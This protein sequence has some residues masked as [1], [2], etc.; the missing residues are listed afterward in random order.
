[1]R[2][3]EVVV[4]HTSAPQQRF[5]LVSDDDSVLRTGDRVGPYTVL[6][7]LG[8]GGMGIVYLARD[9]RL[10]RRV[11]LKLIRSDE[12]DEL[13]LRRFLFEVRAT[14]R[15]NH[16]NIVTVHDAG[17]HEGM[18]Y[19]VLEY[20]EGETLEQRML[21]RPLWLSEALDVALG[22][23]EALS[24]AH[25]HGILHSD[26]KPGNVM[27][28]PHDVVKVLDF[29]LA[30][31]TQV[32]DRELVD[33]ILSGDAAAAATIGGTPSFMAP[34]QWRAEPCRSASDV[35][36]L[37]MLLHEMCALRRPYRAE[38][39][40]NRVAEICRPR[41]FVSVARYAQLP[42]ELAELIDRCLCKRP[43]GRPTAREA[44]RVLRA[45]RDRHMAP[46]NLFRGGAPLG[47]G[48]GVRLVGRDFERMAARAALDDEGALVLVGP[49][50]CGKTSFL[51]AGLLAELARDDRHLVVELRPGRRPFDA[52]E[53]ALRT[54]QAARGVDSRG[55]DSRGVDS[56]E[57][58]R[59]RRPSMPVEAA[60]AHDATK[61]CQRLVRLATR[62]GRTVVLVI[63]PLDDLTLVEPDCAARFLE[64]LAHIAAL[65]RD[66]VRLVMSV[67]NY[68]LNLLAQ[69]PSLQRAAERAYVLRPLSP[70]AL[71]RALEE[72]VRMAGYHWE[73]GAVDEILEAVG[74]GHHA[75]AQ[76]Q[77]IAERIWELR[78]RA[79]LVLRRDAWQR[80]GGVAGVLCQHAARRREALASRAQRAI[81]RVLVTLSDRKRRRRMP[82]DGGA[83]RDACAML[84]DARLISWSDADG[85]GRWV[86]AHD[87][88]ASHALD[89]RARRWRTVVPCLVGAALVPLA[90]GLSALLG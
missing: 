56:R 43:A 45:L 81:D 76:L 53:A 38:G 52:L 13:Y 83:T 64:I 37:G 5:F 85:T 77:L 78:E 28:G 46:D 2:L 33:T 51:R 84:L 11:A 29:G 60:L 31:R 87:A 39:T 20:V 15:F 41:P 73:Q 12:A 59:A 1:M 42:S 55:V 19:V 66:D 8:R 7:P 35:W 36:A 40:V 70:S 17:Q 90:L 48:D 21:R 23:A 44:A 63:D 26:L 22:V 89:Q 74:S 27:F 50:G 71:R 47:R 88:L 25:R 68:A 34:E 49:T 10:G 62:T 14:A 61:V 16:P 75:V 32:G 82:R 58:E 57:G 9:T 24:E 18:P 72:P 67:R 54:P 6:E 79:T 4:M 3:E 65:G 69:H 80:L 86:L 30:Q